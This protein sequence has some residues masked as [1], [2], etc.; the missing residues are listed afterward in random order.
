MVQRQRFA[1]VEDGQVV[2]GVGAQPDHIRHR[3]QGAPAGE[4]FA[5]AGFELLQRRG[6]HDA[7][8]QTVV[9]T[10]VAGGQ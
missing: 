1:F 4:G 3:Q 10:E 8:G 9:L 7:G 5:G 6:D 2:V